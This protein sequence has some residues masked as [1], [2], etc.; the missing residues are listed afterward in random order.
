MK[1]IL[2][3]LLVAIFVGACFLRYNRKLKEK[4]K[5]CS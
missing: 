5:K 2:L 3:I 4:A 1:V